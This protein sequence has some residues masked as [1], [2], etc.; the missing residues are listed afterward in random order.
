MRIAD[1]LETAVSNLSRHKLRTLL[2]VAGVTIGTTTLALMVSV[3][4]GVQQFAIEQTTAMMAKDLVYITNSREVN[5]IRINLGSV[6]A[7]AAEVKDAGDSP[8]RPQPIAP[9]Q[10]AQLKALPHVRDLYANFY[11][12]AESIRLADAEKSYQ[13]Q[14]EPVY[15]GA[16]QQTLVA[17]PGFSGAIEEVILANQYIQVFGWTRPED[18]IGQDVVITLTRRAQLTATT[19]GAAPK[20]EREPFRARVVGVTARTASG[21]SALVPYDYVLEMGRW[22]FRN[23]QIFSPNN[24]GYTGILQVDSPDRVDAV[25]AAVRGL[26]MG[27]LTPAD[28]IG[29]MNTVYAIVEGIFSI[30]GLVALAVASLGISNTLVM[31]IYERTR[32]IGVWKALGATSGEIRLLFTVEAAAIG[33][34]GGAVGLGIAWVIGQ[35]INAIAHATFARDFASFALSAFPA[36]LVLAVLGF[37]TLIGVLAGLLPANRAAH[38]DPVAALRHE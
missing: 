12:Q 20:Q 5:S 19:Y 16:T 14:V 24:F 23:R 17:G 25:A 7:P 38:L 31:A 35:G 30:L 32:E 33:L 8:D 29:M 22:Q 37:S 21:T 4:A 1:L 10:I 18:A 36:W 27:A 9:E 2:T 15:A 28:Q 6:G 13:V 3:A 34:V 26:D 11:V